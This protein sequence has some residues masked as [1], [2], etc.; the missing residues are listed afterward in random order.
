MSIVPSTCPEGEHANAGAF[1]GDREIIIT[2]RIRSYT[3][4][5]FSM[6]SQP[7]GASFCFQSVLPKASSGCLAHSNAAGAELTASSS[8]L[9]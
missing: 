1:R 7:N 3:T 4:R 8:E 5:A 9:A 6:Q 2:E